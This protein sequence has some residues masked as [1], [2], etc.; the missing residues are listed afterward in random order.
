MD[1]IY[2]V[3]D[4]DIAITLTEDDAVSNSSPG[5]LL[6]YRE[7]LI[8]A[9]EP[10]QGWHWWV[11]AVNVEG[12][13]WKY[14]TLRAV[15]FSFCYRDAAAEA[16]EK[17]KTHPCADDWQRG[18]GSVQRLLDNRALHRM[19][20]KSESCV[21]CRGFGRAP[22]MMG[23]GDICGGLADRCGACGGTGKKHGRV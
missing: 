16:L 3:N 23:V 11:E 22:N 21:E 13:E 10:E 1:D 14:D 12:Y 20:S 17:I 9:Y 18:I 2:L 5:N 6:G 4:E 7:T 15:L 19:I 8:L